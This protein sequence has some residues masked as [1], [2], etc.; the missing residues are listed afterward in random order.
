M[1]RPRPTNTNDGT[2][3]SNNRNW[4]ESLVVGQNQTCKLPRGNPRKPAPWQLPPW[5]LPG[6]YARA[7]RTIPVG[8]SKTTK[9]NG[10]RA[11]SRPEE[12]DVAWTP[13]HGLRA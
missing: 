4:K 11:C 2:I 7:A 8:P 3:S 12:S 6:A 9:H 10:A 1:S 5:G 13:R